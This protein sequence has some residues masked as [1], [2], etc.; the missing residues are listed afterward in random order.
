M[1]EAPACAEMITGYFDGRNQGTPE[2]G[3]NRSP[4]YRHGF[5]NGR[6]DSGAGPAAPHPRASAQAMRAKAERLMADCGCSAGL[7]VGERCSAALRAR[8]AG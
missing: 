4:C 8:A 5:A 6:D 3:E 7:S 2:P 1:S